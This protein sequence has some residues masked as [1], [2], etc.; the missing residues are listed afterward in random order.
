MDK[1]G[2][3]VP[4]GEYRSYP[5]YFDDNQQITIYSML[6][7]YLPRNE[8]TVGNIK[9]QITLNITYIRCINHDTQVY[10]KY[11][12]IFYFYSFLLAQKPLH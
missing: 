9:T 2:N 11:G 1:D 7:S 4:N 6:E 10:S 5:I 12:F 8:L 3:I